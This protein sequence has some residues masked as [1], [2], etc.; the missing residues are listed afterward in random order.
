M[1]TLGWVTA[2]VS[3]M[4]FNSIFSGYALSVL[5]GWFIVKTFGLPGLTIPAAIGLA[6]MV[7]YMTHQLNDK[8]NEDD[9]G[10]ILMKGIFRGIE[11]PAFALAFGWVVVQFV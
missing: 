1:K 3:V 7:N 8:K 9:V 2:F 6:M 4:V 5:W 11:K 10:L